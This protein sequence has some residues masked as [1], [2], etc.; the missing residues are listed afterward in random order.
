MADLTVQNL[1][2]A[3]GTPVTKLLLQMK[4]AGL[5]HSSEK[6]LVTEE[7][8]KVLLESIR[9]QSK[10]SKTISLKKKDSET[11]SNV[12][13]I[14]RKTVAKKTVST[15][16]TIQEDSSV[17]NFDEI[18]RKRLAGE[19][20]KKS[21]EEEKKKEIEKKTLVKRKK[22]RSQD[23]PKP[24]TQKDT[25]TKGRKP[26]GR[27]RDKEN[28]SKKE[29]RELEG[30]EF[31]NKQMV[32]QHQ[33]EKPTD[34]V[35]KTIQV[36]ETITVSGLAKELSIK[37]SEV[38]KRLM[39]MGVMATL[40]Q[41][42]DQDTAILVT[43]ELGHKGE[44]S[45]IKEEE[46][47]LKELITYEGEEVP[48]NPVIS[49][50][51]HVDHGKT[52]LLDYIRKAKVAEQE[53]GGITQKIGAY[54]AQISSDYI[55]F[56][57][58]PGHAAFTEVRARGANSTDI[59]VLVV[60]ADDGL[61]P[62]T[63]EAISHAKAANVPIVVAINKIDKD[64]VDIEKVKNELSS[65]DIVSEEWGGKVQMIPVSA[66]TGKGIDDLLEA[67]LLEAE[68]LELK[69]YKK[70]PASGV[71]LDST[72][73][74]GQGA[75]A[76]VI[77][78][79]GTLQ[80]GDIVLVGDQTKKV[81]NLLDENGK[82]LDEAGP[83][84]PVQ[85]TGLENPPKA[86]EEFVVVSNEKMAKEISSER[87]DKQRV[88]KLSSKQAA[89]LENLF[90]KE[91]TSSSLNLILKVDTYGSLEAITGSINNIDSNEVKVNIVHGSVG[92]INANDINLAITTESSVIGFNVRTDSS[93]KS[94]AEENEI[95]IY[96]ASIIYDL[97][98]LIKELV[99]GK[100][101]PEIK[102]EILG[103]AEVKDTFRS[104]QFGLIAG[105]I[106]IEGTIK[107]N[108]YVRVIRDDV[109][110]FEGLLDSLRRFKDDASEVASGTECGIGIENY[111]DVKVG[112]KIEVFDK[113]EIKRKLS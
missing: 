96:Y 63:E 37:S 14:R 29:Q 56:I 8:K 50:L 109:V 54:R 106:V 32:S 79:K 90:S 89:N 33:F 31:L 40:N 16:N 12:V 30:E 45:K 4:D 82:K 75:V 62:Q 58:T 60:A 104:P 81:R 91:T 39:E 38:V 97:L 68:V 22:A 19:E 51:G 44:A 25:E 71:V 72:T 34:A 20:S 69:S 86:G 74:R 110:I 67:I 57:D 5:S 35:I 87:A 111:S 53:H 108:K 15:E 103:L 9:K 100:L 27:L 94:L 24:T 36:P 76:T 93:S 2:D 43:E 48:R 41:T 49:V 77:V 13:K 99:E 55:T 28:V 65:K 52:T 59:V 18:E 78:Q 61:Q 1:A 113:K 112:D 46:D 23:I 3:V 66:L 107:R 95:Q 64:G 102:E 47:Q 88:T 42:L 26:K 10:S 84:V 98:D 17:P 11:P 70:G 6:D 105:S 101:E 73:E 83:S 7:D 92:G 80:S 85:V 21:K